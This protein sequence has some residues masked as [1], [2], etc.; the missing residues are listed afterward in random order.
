MPGP[1]P[2]YLLTPRGFFGATFVTTKPKKSEGEESRD[3]E[4][5]EI[6]PPTGKDVLSS[7]EVPK[8]IILTTEKPDYAVLQQLD[9]FCIRH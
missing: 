5:R 7:Y 6:K 9:T 3:E 8:R 1:R 4:I 2:C